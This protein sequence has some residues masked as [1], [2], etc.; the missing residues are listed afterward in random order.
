MFII[1]I[2]PSNYQDEHMG[3][4]TYILLKKTTWDYKWIYHGYKAPTVGI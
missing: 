3:F 2:S 1:I 4:T